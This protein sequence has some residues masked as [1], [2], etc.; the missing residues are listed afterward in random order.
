MKTKKGIKTIPVV[1][2]LLFTAISVYGQGLTIG[3]GTTFTLGSSTTL[4]LSGNWTDNGTFTAGT[5]STV[6]FNGSSGNQTVTGVETFDNLTINKTIG[7]V[8]LANNINVNGTLTC[9]SGN[10][11][12]DGN[13]CAL[14]SAG[15]VSET[16]GN[17]II[18]G[19]LQITQLLNAPNSSNPGN[20]GAEITS[21]ANLGQT[22]ITRGSAV[23]TGNGNNSIKRYYDIT[24]TTNT[25]L[26][27]T[28]VFH[29]FT[30]ELNGLTESTLSLFK[31]TDGGTNWTNEGGTVNTTA[32]TVTLSGIN[33]FSR[34]T[35][36]STSSPLPVELTS[37]T[38]S[39]KGN[40]VTLNWQTATEVNNYGFEVQ[41][42]ENRN[43]S[44]DWK[45]I[46]FV[47]GNG[48]SNSPNEYS[49]TDKPT[50]GGKFQYR[51]K[52]IDNDGSFEYSDIAEVS[53]NKVTEYKLNQNYPNPFNPSTKL[54]YSI[55]SESFVSLKVY[56]ILGNEVATLVN[57]QQQAGVYRTDFNAANLPSGLY[58]ARITANNFT[59]VVKMTLLK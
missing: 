8:V 7:N 9:T 4:S 22:T 55:P 31:S 45:K 14:G 36:G 30:S 54:E 56:D 39:V 44:S 5:G 51:L 23:Q 35:L 6:I 40:T 52:Q 12:L 43:G 53:L 19:T 25:G 34:W 13:S 10:L 27:A 20:L 57:E 41:R 26:N 38:A 50:L 48:N 46:G 3:S 58:F 42:S 49:F 37:F 28:L 17:G 16:S 11:D 47:E 32:H 18:N 24:P 15:Q 21:N 59:Q 2:L 33:S 1:C 29:Y